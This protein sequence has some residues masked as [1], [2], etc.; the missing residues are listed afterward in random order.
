MN[1]PLLSGRVAIARGPTPVQSYPELAR[2]LGLGALLV[3]RD[4]WLTPEFGGCKVRNLEVQIGRALAAGANTLLLP[5][6]AGSNALAAAALFA[7]RFGLRVRAL[8]KP[9]VDSPLARRNLMLASAAGAAIVPVAEDASLR[10]AGE[11]IRAETETLRQDQTLHLLPFGGGDH[12][13]AAAHVLAAFELRDQLDALR[14]PPPDEIWLAGASFTCAAGLAAGLSLCGLD[15][16]LVVVGVGDAVHYD[17][18]L[19]VR[20]ARAGAATAMGDPAC[21]APSLSPQRFSVRFAPGPGFGH[22]QPSRDQDSS[23]LRELALDPVYTGKA[24]D[25]LATR[26]GWSG[27]ERVLFWHTGNSRPWPSSVARRPLDPACA[28]LLTPSDPFDP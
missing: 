12:D 4:D 17:R 27:R 23:A 13:A 28:A 26:G 16:R 20:K 5:V 6:R 9:Q 18:E 15:S 19:F 21:P 22:A 10:L 11:T 3:K 1:R 14:W 25:A 8:L 7:P 24:F 2:R